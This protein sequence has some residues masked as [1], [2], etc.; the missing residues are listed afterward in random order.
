MKTTRISGHSQLVALALLVACPSAAHSQYTA[1]NI[2]GIEAAQLGYDFDGAGPFSGIWHPAGVVTN[3]LQ[4]TIT[5]QFSLVDVNPAYIIPWKTA[6]PSYVFEGIDWD[7]RWWLTNYAGQVSGLQTGQIVTVFFLYRTG[8]EQ[9]QVSLEGEIIGSVFRSQ[10]TNTPSRLERYGWD[11]NGIPP[12]AL[13]LGASTRMKDETLDF[14]LTQVPFTTNGASIDLY[15][16]V[17]D[18]NITSAIDNDQDHQQDWQ[19][20]ITGMSPFDSNS[21][22]RITGLRQEGQSL[23]VVSWP[24]ASNRSYRLESRT[25]LIEETDGQL[26]TNVVAAPPVNSVTT[27]VHVTGNEFIAIQVTQ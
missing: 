10:E 17:I 12:S 22:F 15:G 23:L 19:E 25:N 3:G 13:V 14:K 27:T 5:P 20:V 24:S 18:T 26:I 7:M 1:F 8:T 6:Q 9:M 21:L 16:I 4:V 11:T 2:P